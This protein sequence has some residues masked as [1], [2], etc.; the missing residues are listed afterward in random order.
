MQRIPEDRAC[1][2]LLV[3]QNLSFVRTVTQRYAILDTGRIVAA[4]GVNELTDAVVRQHL[5]M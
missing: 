1:A 2:V 3:E 5:Q 4:G